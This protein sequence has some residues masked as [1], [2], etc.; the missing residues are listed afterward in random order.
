MGG[1]C[2]KSEKRLFGVFAVIFVIRYWFLGELGID[3][4]ILFIAPVEQESPT[5][6]ILAGVIV[7][8]DLLLLKS[9]KTK[10]KKRLSLGVVESPPTYSNALPAF[11]F[12]LTSV[13][14]GQLSSC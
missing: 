3:A 7:K 6:R 1:W 4:G 8:S 13:C 9:H 10:T 14:R 12:R 11:Y 2:D 5:H